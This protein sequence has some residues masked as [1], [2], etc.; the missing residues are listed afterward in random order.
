MTTPTRGP[1]VGEQIATQDAEFE[2]RTLGQTPNQAFGE[3]EVED[4]ATPVAAAVAVVSANAEIVR[5][6][7][8]DVVVAFQEYQQ[9]QKGLDEAMPD[10]IMLIGS[11]QFRV[12]AYWRAIAVAFNVN[13]TLVS[14]R[15]VEIPNSEG[16]W[17]WLVVYRAAAPNGRVNDGD[18]SCFAS[19]KWSDRPRCPACGEGE[20][21]MRSKFDGAAFYCY[22]AKGGCGAEWDPDPSAPTVLDKSQATTHNVRSH[23]HTRAKNRAIS[24]L[25]GFGEVSAE[26]VQRT[27]APA[28]AGPVKSSAAPTGPART[29]I[30]QKQAKRAAAIASKQGKT[31][32]PEVHG[33]DV[34]R[35]VIALDHDLAA[36]PEGCKYPEMIA[37]L[38]AV[39]APHRYEGFCATIERYRGPDQPLSAGSPTDAAQGGAE[40]EGPP[41]GEAFDGELVQVVDRDTGE[42][43]TILIQD[44]I[45]HRDPKSGQVHYTE[46]PF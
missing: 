10:S 30:T 26:E 38:V 39:V 1:S 20:F 25:C 17:G 3:Y 42:T 4:P 16:D 14:E 32:T 24:D 9:I 2:R 31:I 40:D 15:R 28:E 36:P 21:S 7:P 13:T 19:E 6:A 22:K 5:A 33:F 44:A 41:S 23:A 46:R 18:G 45:E 34:L 11:K 29:S 37:H 8:G 12:K 43:K 35:D 27:E